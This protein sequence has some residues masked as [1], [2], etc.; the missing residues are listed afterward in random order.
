MRVFKTGFLVLLT[1]H[2]ICL[3]DILIYAQGKPAIGL[4][5]PSGNRDIRP[6]DTLL[7]Q[8]SDDLSFTVTDASSRI[9]YRG[10]LKEHPFF[11]AG[12][13]QGTQLV[14]VYNARRK[15]IKTFHFNLSATTVLEDGGTYTKMFNLFKRGML[16]YEPAGYDSVIIGGKKYRYFVQ[17][18]LDNTETQLGMQYFSEAGS[19][20]ADLMQ[21]FQRQDG[22]IWSF[23]SKDSPFYFE[24][25]YKSWGYFLGG[26]QYYFARQPTENHVEYLYVNLIYNSWKASGDTKWMQDKLASAKRALDYSVND[27]TR[28]SSR[29]KLL[30]RAYTIDSWDFQIMDDFYVPLGIGGG[31]LIDSA[32]TKFGVFYGDNTGYIQACRQ[33]AHMDSITGN[34]REATLYDS[35][36]REIEARLDKLAWNGRFYTHR[37]EEDSTVKRSLGVDEKLQVSLSNM[38]SV[39]RGISAQHQK[40]IIETYQALK[41]N[42]PKGS[43]AEWYA[44]FPP[45]EKGFGVHNDKWQYM[46]GGIAGHA[47]GEL[48]RGAFEN[49]F[50]SYGLGIL[51]RLYQLGASNGNRISFAYTGAYP[52]SVQKPVFRTLDLQRVFNMSLFTG[53]A[54]QSGPPRAIPWMGSE[55][56][57]NDFQRMPRGRQVF[58]GIP[59]R[60]TSAQVAAKAGSLGLSFRQGF[61]S[62][63]V[64][65]VDDFAASIYL[66]HTAA[67]IGEDHIA[68]S[69]TLHFEDGTD[70]S[71]YIISGQSITG[72]WFPELSTPLAGVAWHAPNGKSSSV[73]ASWAN[74]ENPEPKKKIKSITFHA[75]RGKA[76]YALLGISLCTQKHP[77]KAPLVSFGGPDN[78]AAATAMAGL[79]EGL[80]GVQNTSTKLT[81]VRFA[82]RWAAALKGDEAVFVCAQLKASG[83][84]FAYRY[85]FNRQHNEIAYLFTGSGKSVMHR[86]LLPPGILK[87]KGI[88]IRDNAGNRQILATLVK[89]GTSA[90]L[91]FSTGL[92]N[93]AEIRIVMN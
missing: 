47:A 90:Y 79:V 17:W 41:H 55:E 30:K 81:T 69:F 52:D 74:F 36:A 38:Y 18:V 82:P 8:G 23:V 2:L 93:P 59:Y 16:V 84:Y 53:P 44:I 13:T 43:P 51:N 28:W 71:R 32:K 70:F 35:R 26:P 60:L 65:P 83:A 48:A 7:L 49:G 63:Q 34:V 1:F 22:M 9:Y 86:V 25:A 85:H 64:I 62:E 56:S 10:F 92:D 78:W 19:E 15:L 37:I 89:M 46:N 45:F 50:E 14:K 77:F 87:I 11:L 54:K 57:G 12:G 75:A 67:A 27:P 39:N 73:G 76:V 88:S 3:G 80:C 68:A 91:N 6:L 29:F 24:T 72:W 40:A 31:M 21:R 42:L 4:L 66:L 33:L 58:A 5:R 20:L 61:P